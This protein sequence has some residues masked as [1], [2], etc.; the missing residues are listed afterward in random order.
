MS[1]AETAVSGSAREVY[2]RLLRYAKPYWRIFAISIVGMLIFAA[3]E[4]VFAAMIKPLLDG[5][6]V[7]RDPDV[8]RTMPILLILLFLVRG[9]AGFV[10]EVGGGGG[11]REEQENE[12]EDF[13]HRRRSGKA[14]VVAAIGE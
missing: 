2:R 3:T 12:D 10:E 6:F 5:S 13:F 4:P 8:V 1:L 11:R 7:D 14:G 9:V